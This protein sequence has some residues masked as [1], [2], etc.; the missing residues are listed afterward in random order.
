MKKSRYQLS[1]NLIVAVMIF[2]VG[3]YVLFP[4]HSSA[5][6]LSG[7]AQEVNLAVSSKTQVSYAVAT[8]AAV[9]VVVVTALVIGALVSVASTCHA[10]MMANMDVDG[11]SEEEYLL[12]LLP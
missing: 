10:E 1:T 9:G 2:A 3:I 5:T 7:R 11:I 12:E 4:F 8:P 6:N